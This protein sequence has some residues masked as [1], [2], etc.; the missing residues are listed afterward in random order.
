M[1]ALGVLLLLSSLVGIALGAFIAF[2]RR[3][4]ESGV[5]FALWWVPATAAAGGILL[6][7]PVTFTIGAFCFL[8][9]GTALVLD[10]YGSRRRPTRGRGTGS[11]STG[12]ESTGRRI[13]SGAAKR[14][15][16]GRIK[17]REYRKVS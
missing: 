1:T 14:W 16:S 6:R 15:L 10:G 4:R 12:P 2:D 8:V 3:T 11:G 5:F 9:A 17:A 7:D 13:L